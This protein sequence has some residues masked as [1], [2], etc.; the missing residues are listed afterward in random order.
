MNLYTCT[1]GCGCQNDTND[2]VC[3]SCKAGI[4]RSKIK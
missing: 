4:C 1:C 2:Y 3:D